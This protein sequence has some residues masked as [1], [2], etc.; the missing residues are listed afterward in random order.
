MVLRFEREKGG[1]GEDGGADLEYEGE[2][3]G[4]TESSQGGEREANGGGEERIE[5]DI[6]NRWR[7]GL[8]N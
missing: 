8:K 3:R 4:E 7:L 2:E 6:R 1:G 5:R